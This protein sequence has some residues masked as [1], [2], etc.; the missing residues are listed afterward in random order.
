MGKGKK[1]IHNLFACRVLEIGNILLRHFC[2]VIKGELKLKE[3][4]EG[5]VIKR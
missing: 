4:S 5:R 3:V 1:D 2:F